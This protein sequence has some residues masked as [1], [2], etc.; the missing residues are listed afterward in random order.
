MEINKF[1]TPRPAAASRVEDEDEVTA[2]VVV[3]VDEEDE[4][5]VVEADTKGRRGA[6]SAG[7]PVPVVS[8]WHT[9]SRMMSTNMMQDNEII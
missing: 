9:H 3:G 2:A 5:M 7:M 1:F 8:Q 6:A 4:V